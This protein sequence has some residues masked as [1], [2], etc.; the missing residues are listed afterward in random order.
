VDVLKAW[1]AKK[2][3]ALAVDVSVVLPQRL[4]DKVAEAVPRTREELSA[5][6][7]LRRWRVAEFA[8]ELIALVLGR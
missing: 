4:L 2:A 8:D 7:G 1:R 3:V 5:I 6:E